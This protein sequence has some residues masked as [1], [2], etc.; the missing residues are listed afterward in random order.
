M[1]FVSPVVFVSRPHSLRSCK[2][3]DDPRTVPTPPAVRVVLFTPVPSLV[4]C[5]VDSSNLN[6]D[7]V[8]PG[9]DP[10]LFLSIPNTS[11]V[12]SS[13]VPVSYLDPYLRQNH[14]TVY[15]TTGI[16]IHTTWSDK[17]FLTTR[18]K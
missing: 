1:R 6:W 4:L 2:C 13:D 5:L 10:S 14:H 11:L 8:V 7:F 9:L 3:P 18:R 12:R 15:T 17:S 16:P